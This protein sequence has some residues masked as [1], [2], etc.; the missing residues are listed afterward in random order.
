MSPRYGDGE[1]RAHTYIRQLHDCSSFELHVLAL[2]LASDFFIGLS[3]ELCLVVLVCSETSN[4]VL[5]C[6]LPHCGS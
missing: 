2:N 6:S 3:D 1:E 4:K 5:E